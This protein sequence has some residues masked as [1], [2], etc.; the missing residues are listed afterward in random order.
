MASRI[1]EISSDV[2]ISARAHVLRANRAVI[3]RRCAW[4]RAYHRYPMT[5]GIASWRGLGVSFTDGMCRGCTIRFRHQWN[6]PPTSSAIRF[7]GPAPARLRGAVTVALVMI[8]V[9]LVVGSS[10]HRPRAT[11]MPPP[12]TV[13]VPAPLEGEPTSP[14]PGPPVPRLARPLASRPVPSSVVAAVAVRRAPGHGFVDADT[15]TE[16]LVLASMIDRPDA[17]SMNGGGA[18]ATGRRFAGR[19]AFAALPHAGLTHQAP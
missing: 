8:L 1:I 9:L 15:E 5:I 14:V 12:E 2:A 11:M 19:S 7:P 3:V 13:F 18:S 17:D 16:P 10:D 6:L 4:H